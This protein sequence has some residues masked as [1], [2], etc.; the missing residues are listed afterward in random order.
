MQLAF[1]EIRLAGAGSPQVTRRLRAALEDLKA[2]APPARQ[3]VL[4]RQLDLLASST[5]DAVVDDRDV[6]TA[7]QPDR[8]GLGVRAGPRP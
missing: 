3:A 8:Q 7:L 5:R 4:D 2:G 6:L 1:E